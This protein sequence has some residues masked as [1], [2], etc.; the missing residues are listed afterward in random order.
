MH[1]ESWCGDL[2]KGN[3]LED[4]RVDSIILLK[5]HLQGGGSK[6]DCIHLARDRGSWR[7]LVNAVM[8]LW[9]L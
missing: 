9:V 5:V 7:A 2:G 1:T 4:P 3:H 6:T 8:N